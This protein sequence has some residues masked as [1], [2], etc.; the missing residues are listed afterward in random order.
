MCR[1]GK[2]SQGTLITS[3]EVGSPK[4]A[5]SNSVS[6]GVWIWESLWVVCL[7]HW[8]PLASGEARS[9]TFGSFSEHLMSPDDL[10]PKLQHQSIPGWRD[11]FRT[12]VQFSASYPNSGLIH[13]FPERA[14][15]SAPQSVV[16]GLV[17]IANCSL[18][19]MRWS[20]ESEREYLETFRIPGKGEPGG[21]PSMGSHK[22]GHDWSDAAAAAAAAAGQLDIVQR[23][24]SMM[25]VSKLEGKFTVAVAGQAWPK[26]RR[27]G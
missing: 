5:E 11:H 4:I 22:V 19:T 25:R 21:L 23:S 2:S 16:C 14:L 27:L 7:E 12:L 3:E 17:R 24:K 20:T 6:E 9:E 8:P 13:H 1:K 26:W 18:F 15:Y 10:L